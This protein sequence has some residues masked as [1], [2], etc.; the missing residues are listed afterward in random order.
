[1]Y[2]S[3]L[4]VMAGVMGVVVVVVVG[5]GVV[6]SGGGVSRHWFLSGSVSVEQ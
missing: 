6:V 3:G 2:C 1:M 4:H 5:W